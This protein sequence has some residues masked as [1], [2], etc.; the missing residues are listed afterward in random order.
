MKP[1]FNNQ[2][3]QLPSRGW[4]F[5]RYQWHSVCSGHIYNVDGNYYSH[6]T[7][8]DRCMAGHWINCWMHTIG[9]FMHDRCYPLW[10]WWI[11]RS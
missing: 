9:N 7:S 3:N 4:G 6:D 11:N 1:P 10:F 8:C 5:W 2:R